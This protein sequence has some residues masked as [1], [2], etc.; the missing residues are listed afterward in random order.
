MSEFLDKA[1]GLLSDRL[2]NG[3]EYR[4]QIEIEDR[5]SIFVDGT[6]VRVGS[7]DA[8][9]VISARSD[10]YKLIINGGLDPLNAMMSG[11]LSVRGDLSAAASL[12]RKL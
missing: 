3:I 7:G 12:A 2:T 1:A 4:V 6:G 9:C 5:G 11:D 8:D 10:I